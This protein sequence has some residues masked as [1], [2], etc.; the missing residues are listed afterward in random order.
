MKA[1]GRVIDPV[2]VFSPYGT[3]LFPYWGYDRLHGELCGATSSSQG[4]VHSIPY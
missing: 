2:F 4:C 1:L 3:L